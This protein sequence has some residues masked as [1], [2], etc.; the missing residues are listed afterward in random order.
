MRYEVHG[1]TKTKIEFLSNEIQARIVL[2]SGDA[3]IATFPSSSNFQSGG[4]FVKL[5]ARMF[6]LHM[7]GHQS[8]DKQVI[9]QINAQLYL[10]DYEMMVSCVPD[11]DKG[12]ER[13][14]IG[15]K[16]RE[17]RRE[18]NMEAKELA[19][20]IGIDA[21]NLSRIEQGHYSVG[22]DTLNKIANALGAKVDLVKNKILSK[23]KTTSKTTETTITT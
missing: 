19:R 6:D 5:L 18:N 17:L 1:I 8:P 22:F 16:I 14:R 11:V 3:Y 4:H 10:A 21:S 12:E 2:M 9:K 15:E 23:T 7:N 13:K 20:R